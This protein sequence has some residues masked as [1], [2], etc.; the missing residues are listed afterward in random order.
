MGD[1]DGGLGMGDWG[2]GMG[3]E[4]GGLSVC[5]CGFLIDAEMRRNE[6]K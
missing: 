4:E 5:V 3:D 2:W 6:K 1:G